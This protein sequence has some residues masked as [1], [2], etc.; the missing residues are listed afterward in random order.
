[1][2]PFLRWFPMILVLSSVGEEHFIQPVPT[3]LPPPTPHVSRPP[4][5]RV[6][7]SFVH[8]FC[9]SALPPM[10]ALPRPLPGDGPF[11]K[12]RSRAMR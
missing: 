3:Q 1:V 8:F 7:G 9:E 10:A 2:S 6:V 5:A 11:S 4:F 12:K